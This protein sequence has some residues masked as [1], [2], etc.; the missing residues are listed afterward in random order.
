MGRGTI[1]SASDADRADL[2]L[3]VVGAGVMGR[4][5]AQVAAEAGMTVLLADAGAGAAE[6]ARDFAAGMIRRKVDK[7]TLDAAEAEAA[8]GRL[9]ATDAGPDTGY[10]ALADC[11]VIV[12]AVVE[13]LDVKRTL[14]A[15][16]EDQVGDGCVIASNTSSL[17]VTGIAARARRP[18]RIAGFH[19][20]NPVPLMK[21]VEV[22][23]GLRTDPGT[24]AFLTALARRMGHHPL[25]ATDTPGF[26][27]NHAGRAFGTEGLR[28]VAEGICGVADVDRVMT[29]AAGF[30]M[31]PFA[32]FDLTGLDVS[33]AVIES[34]YE[35]YY[36]EPR[37]RPVAITA[38]RVEAGLL[39]RKTGR[40]FYDYEDGK[41][42][43][44]PEAPAP[45]VDAG[46]RP[47]WISNRCRRERGLLAAII[48]AA[49]ATVEEGDTPSADALI[50]VTPYGH[51]ATASALA[52]NLDPV[53]TVAVDMLHD[54]KGR[55]TIMASPAIDP[56]I[57]N[58]AHALLAADG[59]PVT[60]IGDSPGF[61]AQRIIACIV[62]IGCDLAQQRVASPGDIDRAVVLGLGYP[63]GSLAFGDRLG[64]RRILAILDAMLALYGDPR[65]RPSPWLR[66]RALLDLP[67]TAPD[68]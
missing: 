20:F 41:S 47:V 36:Q 12:E 59:T 14:I 46:V 2:V 8:I 68:R 5:I 28:I 13:R 38:Q 17:S 65:Y 18:Q 22:I 9:R 58:H 3:G 15:D 55:R 23:G 52:E 50:L 49:G 10:A 51:D 64:P 30:R 63:H 31:G 39:G 11:A 56:V 48:V 53:R 34:I 1:P 26:L 25:R 57:R 21:L 33:H 60:A 7:G 62:N 66:R 54:L 27:V 6:A 32:L 24:L 19:F 42:V 4:G 16:L 37:Y 29:Q 35:R 45:T 40:G 67:L 43:P 44:I 61:I